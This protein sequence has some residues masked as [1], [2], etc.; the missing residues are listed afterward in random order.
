MPPRN[1][2]HQPARR[3]DRPAAGLTALAILLAA[4]LAGCADNDNAPAPA[5]RVIVLGFDGMDPQIVREMFEAGRLPN[6]A[7][8]A[9]R[10]TFRELGTTMPPQ[11]PV[12]W[13]DFICGTGANLHAIF[14]FIHRDPDTLTQYLSTSRTTAPTH[15]LEIGDW[16]IPLGGG[17]TELLRRGTPFWNYLT[18][19]SI[20]ATIFRIPANYPPAPAPG[21]HFCCLSGMGT[22][23]LKGTYGLFSFYTDS[24]ETGETAL[25]GGVRYRMRTIDH[26]A[27]AAL[28]GPPD[29]FRKNP[30]GSH[31]EM[32]VPFEIRRDPDRPV[33]LIRIQDHDIL[34]NEGEWS[35]WIAIDFKP[36]MPLTA[37]SGICR[38]YLKRVHPAIELYVTPINIDPLRP[39]QTISQP[40]DYAPQLA[41]RLGRFYTLGIPEDTKALVAG[42]LDDDEFLAQADI[43]LEERIA[44][45]DLALEQFT[46]GFLFFY[47]GSTDL[48][49]HMFWRARD[50]QHPLYTPE[51]GRRYGRLLEDLYDRM[52]QQ[53]GK[54]MRL[55]DDD[56]VLIVMSDHGF[57]TF[58]RAFNL[59][60]W[61]RRNGYLN[62]LRGARGTLDVF[63]HTDWTRTRAYGLGLNGLY[64]NLKGRERYGIVEPA[65]SDQLL[66]E[67]T[68]ALLAVTDPRTGQRVID[69]VYRTDRLYRGADAR[70][71]PDLLIGYAR[72]YRASWESAAGLIAPDL[73]RDNTEPWSG[74]HCIAAHLV[75]G[76]LVTNLPVTVPDPALIDLAPSI[77]RLYGLRPPETMTGRMIF[78][79]PAG[80]LATASAGLTRR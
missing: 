45:Y 78:P 32:L 30:D 43:V 51:L 52:D 41:K 49:A 13:A 64:L 12:A 75:P 8:L 65:E 46:G 59:N 18:A 71:A 47:F 5:R 70:L 73:V 68:Q 56:D 15:E 62:V 72:G 26:T 3:P 67:L 9:R 24:T 25:G 80:E 20:P 54:A 57:T 38:F 39:A 74:D 55:L 34:L 77:L 23:D 61:L 29:P 33:A 16:A 40:P 14:D 2:L 28:H 10:G 53:V 76:I 22:P 4:L 27:R 17:R 63:R 58:R 35:D 19:A 1:L 7:R 69:R 21:A 50:T 42:V 44:Q 31:P 6:L 11:S 36:A 48:L 37:V 60:T 66:D 79:E